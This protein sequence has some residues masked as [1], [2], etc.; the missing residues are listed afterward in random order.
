MWDTVDEGEEGRAHC[1][2]HI[3]NGEI[4]LVIN[5]VGDKISQ[6]DSASIRRTALVQNVPYQTTMAGA[7]ATLMAIE[8]GLKGQLTVKPFE[9][10]YAAPHPSPRPRRA[11]A[12]RRR[13]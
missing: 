1:V 13:T 6:V 2:D 4:Q 10:Y 5:T 12:G 11:G 7:R 9:E 8:A 3:K